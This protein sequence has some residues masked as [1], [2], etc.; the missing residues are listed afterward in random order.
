MI[1]ILLPFGTS[2]E[3]HILL[4]FHLK[5]NIIIEATAS[6]IVICNVLTHWPLGDFNKMLDK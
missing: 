4:K 3:E 5:F 1:Q 2:A 6:E